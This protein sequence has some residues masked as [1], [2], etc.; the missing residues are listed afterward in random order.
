MQKY[1]V[2]VHGKRDPRTAG[3][4]WFA[5]INCTILHR[6]DGPAVI[7]KNG[8]KEWYNNGMLHRTDGPAITTS[9]GGKAWWVNDKK[10]RTDGPAIEE[11]DGTKYWYINN[12][13]HRTDG[14]AVEHPGGYKEWWLEG[15]KVTEA[16]HTRRTQP[17][18][19]MTVAQIEAALGHKVKVVK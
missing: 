11:A 15:V 16:E 7:R 2:E 19:E 8:T 5:D 9:E 18:Q 3:T 12:K 6:L 14:P 13:R 1:Y 10:H 17:A 4:Y